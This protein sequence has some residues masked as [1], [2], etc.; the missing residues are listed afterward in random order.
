MFNHIVFQDM[1]D[2]E[3]S[4]AFV[5][6]G[7]KSA[8]FDCIYINGVSLAELTVND[9][10][11]TAV[12]VNYGQTDAYT[13]DISFDSKSETYSAIRALIENGDGVTV[14]IKSGLKFTTGCKVTENREF[15]IVNYAVTEE[16][17][18]LRDFKVYYGGNAVE[19]GAVVVTFKAPSESNVYVDGVDDYEI[20]SSK[21]DG[22]TRFTIT[23]ADG[24]EFVFD[25]D[26]QPVEV[27]QPEQP[28]QPK[29]SGCSSSVGTE[30]LTVLAVL[31]VAACVMWRKR[32]E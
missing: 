16:N 4:A 29:S 14:E 13:L 3:V 25:V 23:L 24:R 5:A 32:Y 19:S 10:W 22:K 26:Y 8:L 6:G 27:E 21:A 2:K 11:I 20:T 18:P 31:S 15:K 30:T 1:Y 9:S 12:F 28:E 17:Q 7:F